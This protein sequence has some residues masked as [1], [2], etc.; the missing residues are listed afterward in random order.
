MKTKN[1]LAFI[2]IIFLSLGSLRAQIIKNGY[3]DKPSY[4]PNEM[5]SLYICGAG[6]YQNVYIYLYDELGYRV[7]SFKVN[8]APQI[9][10]SAFPYMEGFGYSLSASYKVPNL[11]SGLY[12]FDRKIFFILK[13]PEPKK[14]TI[15]CPTNTFQAYDSSGGKSLYNSNSTSGSRAQIISTQRPWS[16]QTIDWSVVKVDGLLRWLLTQPDVDYRLIS[17]MDMDEETSIAGSEIVMIIGHS[18]YWTRAARHNFDNFV[19]NGGNAAMLS[20]NVMWWQV[21]Y[22]DDKTKMICYR[23]GVQDVATDSLKTI[24]W[25]NPLLN[26]PVL[27]SIGCDWVHGAYGTDPLPLGYTGYK[28]TCPA[29]PLLRA[30]GLD[31]GDTIICRSGEYDG[32][33]LTGFDSEGFPVIDTA[34]L[35]FCKTELVAYDLG[36][37]PSDTDHDTAYGTFI[38]FKKNAQSGIVI[39]A[40]FNEFTSNSAPYLVPGRGWHASGFGGPDSLKIKQ[41]ARNIIDVLINKEN[42]FSTPSDCLAIDTTP[43]L[44]SIQPGPLAPQPAVYPNPSSGYVNMQTYLHQPYAFSLYDAYGRK[45]YEAATN[46]KATLNQFNVSQLANGSYIYKI[47]YRTG[48][49][50]TGRLFLLK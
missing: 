18:E 48:A 9:P 49:N 46:G 19:N 29:S 5:A 40:A 13:S 20:G 16:Q 15:V 2:C 45:V 4:F 28:I 8:V 10:T 30:T 12:S 36:K 50:Y 27:P 3:A 42:P 6:L 39:N 17:D 34:L 32:A 38:V 41:I 24:N 21:R 1:T 23:S 25:S 37:R 31:R 26:Y 7:D 33:P 35:G 22:S 14:I 11:P 44:T 47:D 43:V